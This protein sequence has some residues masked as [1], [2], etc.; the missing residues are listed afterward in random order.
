MTEHQHRQIMRPL[1]I[2]SGSWK[3]NALQG[4]REFAPLSGLRQM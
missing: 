3:E 2:A 1:R 4:I